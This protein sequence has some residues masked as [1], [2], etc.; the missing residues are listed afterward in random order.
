MSKL[1]K[2]F[3]LSLSLVTGFAS[4]ENKLGA[5]KETEKTC[6]NKEFEVDTPV[7]KLGLTPRNF[8][9]GAA[10]IIPLAIAQH[11]GVTLENSLTTF[12]MGCMWKDGDLFASGLGKLACYV[13]VLPGVYFAS[14]GVRRLPA[15]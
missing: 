1:S 11:K 14:K 12:G 3:V 2:V 4:A 6:W 13:A 15:Q 10:C 5:F 9:K 7:A 8:V